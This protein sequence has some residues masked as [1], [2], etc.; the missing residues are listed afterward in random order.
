MLFADKNIACIIII[1]AAVRRT[2]QA[3]A[4]T[5]QII[6]RAQGPHQPAVGPHVNGRPHRHDAR[7][8]AFQL[9]LQVT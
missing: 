4:G 2:A 5:A 3:A 9:L 8:L 6:A 1:P 7:S